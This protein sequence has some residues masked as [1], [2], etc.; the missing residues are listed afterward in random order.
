MD[1]DLG[2][3]LISSTLGGLLPVVLAMLAAWV[4]TKI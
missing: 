3:M 4:K 2:D 1:M